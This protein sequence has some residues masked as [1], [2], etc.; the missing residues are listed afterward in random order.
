M[1]PCNF[2]GNKKDLDLS[3]IDFSNKVEAVK[4]N[5]GY[6][7]FDGKDWFW[8]E[9]KELK[10]I[11]NKTRNSKKFYNEDYDKGRGWFSLSPLELEIEI[12]KKCNQKCIHCWNESEKNSSL[13]SLNFDKILEMI[14]E[15]RNF[16][17]QRVLITG[18]EPLLYE[19][20]EGILRYCNEKDVRRLELIT[21]GSLIN[22]SNADILSKYLKYVNVSIHGHDSKSHDYITRVKGSF[23]R[24]MNGVKKL[25]KKGINSIIYFTVMRENFDSIPKMFNLI[26]EL[27]CEAIRFSPVNLVGRAKNQEEMSLEGKKLLSHYISKL[28]KEK[29]I[30]LITSE[31][32]REDYENIDK[33]KFFGCNALR[34]LIYIGANGE[35]YPCSLVRDSIGNIYESSINQI[36]K[37]EKSENFREDSCDKWKCGILE[38]CGGKCKSNLKF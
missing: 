17:G 26:D 1:F 15:F 22:D 10:E 33:Y 18:G 14:N 37:S 34:S 6:G 16:G 8:V 20:L 4:F 24:A 11:R 29:N 36:W 5:I 19:R 9:K 30:K 35:V 13:N 31:L 38:S 23:N 3:L 25:Q 2:D 28:G 12:T 32:S 27:G 21:N 7:V